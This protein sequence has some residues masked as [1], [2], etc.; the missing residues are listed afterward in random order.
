MNQTRLESLVESVLNALIGYLTAIG[1][2]MMIFP[3]FDIHVSAG[4]N[5]K[6]AAAFTVLSIART[7]VIRRWCNIWLRHVVTKVSNFI[8]RN[9]YAE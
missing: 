9:R 1:F 5:F 6:L 2:Q 4:T 7:Y 3:V 8:N